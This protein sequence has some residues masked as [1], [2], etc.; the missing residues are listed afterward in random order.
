MSIDRQTDRQTNKQTDRQIDRQTDRQT[1]RKKLEF[2]FEISLLL[3]IEVYLYSVCAEDE[4]AFS[5]PG[6]VYHSCYIRN[7]I[8][9]ALI[10]WIELSQNT[11]YVRKLSKSGYMFKGVLV[12][13]EIDS[14]ILKIIIFE[15]IILN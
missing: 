15:R 6:I 11:S 4:A 14:N 2:T 7:K 8:L 3:F 10:L 5:E 13:F 9:T 1:D 12:L